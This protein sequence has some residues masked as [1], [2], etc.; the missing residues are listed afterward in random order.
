MSALLVLEDE[1]VVITASESLSYLDQATAATPTSHHPPLTL[2]LPLATHHSPL[3]LHPNSTP[4]PN[5]LERGLETIGLLPAETSLGG[6][7]AFDL[8]AARG[9]H[10][11]RANGGGDGGGGS[12]GGCVGGAA[13][14]ALRAAGPH[15]AVAAERGG[16]I[17]A[18]WVLPL[19]A[20]ATS[21]GWDAAK[22][23]LFVGTSSGA[24]KIF[25][26]SADWSAVN[27]KFAV[28]AH[29]ARVSAVMV[30]P[31]P[32]RAAAVP[33]AAATLSALEEEVEQEQEEEFPPRAAVAAAAAGDG[34]GGSGGSGGSGGGSGG[35]GGGDPLGVQAAAAAETAGPLLF[36]TRGQAAAQL[37]ADRNAFAYGS[38]PLPPVPAAGSSGDGGGGS[39][40]GG[41]GSTAAGGGGVAAGGGNGGTA[42]GGSGGA[43]AGGAARRVQVLASCSAENGPHALCLYDTDSMAALH[44][45]QLLLPKHLS[46]FAKVR[47]AQRPVVPVPSPSGPRVGY[48]R[49]SHAW[50]TSPCLFA[51]GATTFS[52]P[53][54]RDPRAQHQPEDLWMPPLQC[55]CHEAQHDRL[56][57]GSGSAS[58][59]I[60]PLSA[61]EMQCKHVLHD[62][63]AASVCALA[64]DE[65]RAL[66][67]SASHDLSVAIWALGAPGAEARTRRAS[68]VAGFSCVVRSLCW[69]PS[70]A[71]GVTGRLVL[72][73]DDGTLTEWDVSAAHRTRCYAP[74]A[75]AVTCLALTAGGGGGGATAA[76]VTGGHDGTLSVWAWQPEV[77]STGE[78]RRLSRPDQRHLELHGS[79]EMLGAPMPVPTH[80]QSTAGLAP[81]PPSGGGAA[82]AATAAYAAATAAYAEA[83]AQAAAEAAE[84]AARERSGPF[85][86]SP[87]TA[88]GGSGQAYTAPPPPL[89][90]PAAPAPAPGMTTVYGG[91][92]AY[93]GGGGAYGG[94]AD[95]EE[96]HAPPASCGVPDTYSSYP[97]YETYGSLEPPQPPRPPQHPQHPP[98]PPSH[99]HPHPLAADYSPLLDGEYLSGPPPPS[100]AEPYLHGD[101]AT[102]AAPLV[103]DDSMGSGADAR[104]DG[105]VDVPDPSV[106]V[107]DDWWRH[108]QPQ[109]P[110]QPMSLLEQFVAGVP[111]DDAGPEYGR[112]GTRSGWKE[113]L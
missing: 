87:Y 47:T 71:E 36:R 48:G 41:G 107:P 88:S 111:P 69:R 16:G 110:A 17:G 1:G 84:A 98:Q 67:F 15:V 11:P 32:K 52:Q 9:A 85:S 7:A 53:G 106:D 82:V 31:A 61:A 105:A 99:P 101:S 79:L 8:R 70:S 20:G 103:N 10:A 74:H 65:S 81:S 100:Y 26:V 86:G 95:Y 6:I 112:V 64:C 51:Q 5:Q 43:A 4:T 21:L 72:G 109:G 49:G 83:T 77:G 19:Q 29:T 60:L 42:T 45:G 25:V 57:I 89:A 73:A 18:R 80:A 38:A 104:G 46:L 78:M 113:G 91:D 90:T 35:G 59:L 40:R 22:R 76:A 93:G 75:A 94:G 55:M 23:H 37:A 54:E 50:L 102:V 63:H 34:G 92:G 33:P 39:S 96:E 62:A 97:T 58:I 24:V 108:T 14:A 30:L 2:T 27:Y 66:L 28:E 68:R 13:S 12:G 44:A 56:F 3:N